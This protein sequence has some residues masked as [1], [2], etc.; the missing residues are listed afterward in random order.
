MQTRVFAVSQQGLGKRKRSCETEGIPEN[1]M[2]I[3]SCLVCCCLVSRL[4]PHLYHSGG[5]DDSCFS[6]RYCEPKDLLDTVTM[7]QMLHGPQIIVPR[8]LLILS[9]NIIPY[10]KKGNV[11]PS[12]VM[13]YVCGTRVVG[14]KP[15]Y[16]L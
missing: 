3:R 5:K 9:P 12:T 13:K 4:T 6:F 16:I 15:N 2:S 8:Y 11:L 1:T 10:P 7:A 14:E